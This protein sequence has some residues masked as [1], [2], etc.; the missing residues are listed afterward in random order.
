MPWLGSENLGQ[1]DAFISTGFLD[2]MPLPGGDADKAGNRFE[3][4]W[5]VRQLI[6]LLTG[7][8]AWI[9]L[10]PIGAEG[11]RV[12]FRLERNDGRIEAHQVKR[13]QAGKGH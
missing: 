12:E 5:T 9:Q 11:E 8:A 1:P 6:R 7:G 10:E 2:V 13:Q 4:R 3:L